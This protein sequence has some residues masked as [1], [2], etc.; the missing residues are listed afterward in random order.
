MKQLKQEKSGVSET[1]HYNFDVMKPFLKFG[2]MAMGAI[3]HTLIAIVK[4]IP[5]LHHDDDKPGK[6]RIIKI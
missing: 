2:A 5:K 4:N 1:H 3:G 6:D